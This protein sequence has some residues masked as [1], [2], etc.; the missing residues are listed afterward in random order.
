M[1]SFFA[2]LSFF[3]S[4]VLL[5][6]FVGAGFFEPDI[7]LVNRVNDANFCPSCCSDA[8]LNT[9]YL[10]L[11]WSNGPPTAD[12]NFNHKIIQTGT[13]STGL[14]GALH[15][16]NG[17]GMVPSNAVLD[18]WGY[19][20][21]PTA[22]ATVGNF[23]F[24][25]N[26]IF[27]L[28]GVQ[29]TVIPSAS[30]N[31]T[32]YLPPGSGTI[33]SLGSFVQQ[34]SGD[35]NFAGFSVFK[36]DANYLQNVAWRMGCYRVF[37]PN[38]LDILFKDLNRSANCDIN[39]DVGPNSRILFGTNDVFLPGTV[40]DLTTPLALRGFLSVENNALFQSNVFDLQKQNAFLDVSFGEGQ[41]SQTNYTLDCDF[42]TVNFSSLY[43][44]QLNDPGS[45]FDGGTNVYKVPVHG[46]YQILTRL[47][48]TDNSLADSFGQGSDITN[49]DSPY[50]MWFENN[51]TAG[52]NR[53]ST[54]NSRISE[55]QVDDE[56]RMLSYSDSCS[57][58]ASDGSMSI[59]LLYPIYEE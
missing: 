32:V 14:A 21:S 43:N 16:V 39:F 9:K 38:G 3:F 50:F 10:R 55:F 30:S 19:A 12:A 48:T 49:A 11:D 54:L 47:R 46:V 2:R 23:Q 41:G 31:A 51:E 35:L 58:T 13:P 53:T 57:T 36:K 25:K 33:A 44:Y 59:N 45:H 17:S 6:G 7:L 20:S 5:V 18:W 42:T 37:S 34:F 22:M 40:F 8:N 29:T 28:L 4:L 1:G 52:T 24:Y 15:S 27:S 56:I 26:V